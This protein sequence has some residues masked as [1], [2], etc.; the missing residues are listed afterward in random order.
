MKV[1]TI[2][3]LIKRVCI[4]VSIT[5]KYIAQDSKEKTIHQLILYIYNIS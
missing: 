3:R 5:E 1:Y 4:F 2:K